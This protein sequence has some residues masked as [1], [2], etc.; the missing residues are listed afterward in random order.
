[1]PRL[2]PRF[3][4]HWE[5]F[6]LIECLW[7]ARL[8]FYCV[9]Q[10]NRCGIRDG[11]GGWGGLGAT[12]SSPP[13]GCRSCK[14]FT[15]FGAPAG[16]QRAALLEAV[17]VARIP[18]APAGFFPSLSPPS[19]RKSHPS[20]PPPSSARAQ[21]PSSAGRGPQP[22]KDGSPGMEGGLMQRGMERWKGESSGQGLASG[23][24]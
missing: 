14:L 2:E 1:M 21:T 15:C 22:V 20:F 13:R 7:I 16:A 10:T 12:K 5:Y 19:A 9:A 4:F 24:E 23:P 6:C 8:C 3:C 18:E 11:A 17:H